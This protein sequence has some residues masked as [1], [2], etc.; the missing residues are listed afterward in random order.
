MKSWKITGL[1][2]AGC[3]L[4]AACATPEARV[5]S[6]LM[7]AGLSAPVSAC[8]ADRM[9][10][11]LS[12]GQLRKLGDLGKLKKRD[13]GEV[14]VKEFVKETRSLQDP[15]ILAVVTSSG[16]ICAVQ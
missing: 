11:R 5:R 16:L 9:V 14:T 2:L 6:G 12:L 8:M 15:E 4:L 10:D 13:P 3:M 7:S 1:T